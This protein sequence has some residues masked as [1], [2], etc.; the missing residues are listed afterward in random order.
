[1]N[2]NKSIF[3]LGTDI[4]SIERFRKSVEKHGDVFLEK[5]FLTAEIAYCK[6]HADPIP[7]FAA[8]FSAKE[9]IVK[10]LGE[11]FGEKLAFHDIEI[12][13]DAKG[14]PH[15]SLS[16]KAQKHFN[17]P[18]F[19]LSLSHCKEYATATAIALK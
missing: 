6:K 1:M 3:G 15:V 9:A 7:S 18:T 13:K 19:H 12:T 16:E 5:L 2:E 10:A 14:K 4:I 8:R 11:G 17:A